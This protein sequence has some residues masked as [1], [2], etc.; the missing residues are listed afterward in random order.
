MRDVQNAMGA[1]SY[2]YDQV[3]DN[4][5]PLVNFSNM[6]LSSTLFSFLALAEILV[7]MGAF[8]VPW[9]FA[10]LIC[11]WALILTGHPRVNMFLRSQVG[12]YDQ[13]AR[14]RLDRWIKEDA[15]PDAVTEAREVE[16]FELQR[17]SPLGGWE[18]CIFS[19][20]PY[21]ALSPRR[22]VGKPPDGGQHLA[23]VLPLSGWQWNDQSWWTLDLVGRS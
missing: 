4:I 14:S 13:E 17:A 18:P 3:V 8:I 6:G 10:I 1:Y 12:S 11:G 7:V 22:I 20:S 16:I 5:V 19:P 21:E 15:I 2:A 9:R 23:D